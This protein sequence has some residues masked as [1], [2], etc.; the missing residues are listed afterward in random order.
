MTAQEIFD[1][2]W[3]H[4][5]TE[6]NPRSVNDGGGCFYRNNSGGR[7]A[8]GLLIPDAEYSPDLDTHEDGT[9]VLQ[10]LQRPTCPP[11]IAALREHAELLSELQYAHDNHHQH[12]LA[13]ALRCVAESN[14]LTV[15]S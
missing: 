6:G 4:F 3:R 5:V 9:S 10:M 11:S 1:R 12:E 2:V 14:R 15:P 7:C 8:V 13:A